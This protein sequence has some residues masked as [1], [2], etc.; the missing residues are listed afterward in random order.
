[1]IPSVQRGM[2][3]LAPIASGEDLVPAACWPDS[4]K[5]SPPL[6]DAARLAMDR[7]S[8]VVN[9]RQDPEARPDSP[10]FDIACPLLVDD[11][12]F[13][14]VAVE[15]GC[16][17]E[18]RRVVTQLLQWGAAWLEFL[19]RREASS[20][21][22]RLVTVVDIMATAV[23]HEHFVPSATAVT[24]DLTRSLD[25][26]RVW[27]GFSE[28]GQMRVRALSH[29]ASFEPKANLVHAV[30]SAMDEAA[31]QGATLVHPALPD[32]PSY[33]LVAH[34]K[35]SRL[36]D[37]GAVCTVPLIQRETVIGA[38]TLERS[39]ERPFDKLTLEVCEAVAVLLGPLLD[40]KRRRDR[41]LGAKLR[42]EFDH[43]VRKLVGPRHTTFKLGCITSVLIVA[44]LTFATGDYRVAAEAGVESS[45]MR[46]VVAPQEGYI[47]SALARAGDTVSGGEVL[48]TLDPKDLNLE[49]V[50]WLTQKDQLVKEHRQALA[51]R[52]RAKI[53]I[54]RAGIEQAD[55]QLAFV[56][57]RLERSQLTAP[58]DGL[59]ISGDLSQ[60]VGTPVKRGEVLFEVAPIEAYRIAIEVDERDIADVGVGQRGQVALSALPDDP[61]PF[62]VER[63]T[64]VSTAQRGRNFFRVEARLQRPSSYLRPGMRGIAKIDVDQ[65]KLVWIWT[66]TLFEWLRLS[67]WSWWS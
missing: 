30:E 18:Q 49:R 23:E 56:D 12:L 66:H 31:D 36:N 50:K 19:V 25:C 4:T 41:W 64:P 62:V 33:P 32:E 29:S 67:L 13:G 24:T 1:M 10:Q 47:G 8:A 53:R 44:F 2:V 55:A 21:S 37:S 7:M 40:I 39:R 63:L 26:N 34:E 27:L 15:V 45:V 9:A 48:A 54:L 17:D 14:V 28:R 65:R 38:L 16:S 35:L 59:V 43:L 52:D 57:L 60:S 3:V 51:K 5:G 20:L 11:K 42:E 58:F 6:A 61:V 22:T 46:A